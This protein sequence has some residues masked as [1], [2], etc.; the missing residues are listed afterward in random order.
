[1][2]PIILSIVFFVSF[3]VLILSIVNAR[4][5]A[6]LPDLDMTADDLPPFMRRVHD[7][8]TYKFLVTTSK[9]VPD[10]YYSTPESRT[11]ANVNNLSPN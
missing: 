5:L 3:T 9:P 2:I 7:E 1:M 6:S 4:E 11:L 10:G 8:D